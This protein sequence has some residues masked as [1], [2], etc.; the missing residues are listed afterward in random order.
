MNELEIENKAK[1][2]RCLI[3]DVDGV[4]TNGQIS[5]DTNG[6]EY[7]SFNIQDGLGIKLLQNANI[8]V[9]IITGSTNSIIDHRMNQ[10][11]ID[12][13]FKGQINKQNAYN[14]LKS[15]LNLNDDEFAYIGDDL[16]D[17]SIMKQVGLSIAVGNAVPD[18]KFIAD[19]NTEL[20]GGLGAVRE[21]CDFI[22]RAQDMT[23][24]ALERFL[25]K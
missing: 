5:I 11:K 13:F 3:C 9:A 23:N 1:K 15:R 17:I 19:L 8:E 2:I 7:K 20:T 18:V 6:I 16:P 14:Q 25:N 22:L 24:I 21:A 10:L 4:L 12:N